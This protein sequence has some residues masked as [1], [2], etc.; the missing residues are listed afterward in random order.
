MAYT[1]SPNDIYELAIGAFRVSPSRAT[2]ERNES[3]CNAAFCIIQRSG[4]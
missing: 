2:S 3:P 4:A 1:P